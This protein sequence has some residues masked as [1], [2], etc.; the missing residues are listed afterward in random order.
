MYLAALNMARKLN[1]LGYKAKITSDLS[2]TASLVSNSRGMQADIF[3]N[4]FAAVAAGLG[5]LSKCGFVINP[6]HGAE[7]RYLA[8]V[9]DAKLDETA[10]CDAD[11]A[12]A[13]ASCD[14]CL[15]ACRT[16]A[17]QEMIEFELDGLTEKFHRID[18]NRCEWAKRYSFIPE[19][20]NMFMG[21]DFKIETPDQVT[22]DNLTEAMRQTPP[23][24]KHHACNFEK[25]FMACPVV[26]DQKQ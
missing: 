11:P 14:S 19:S 20:G 21:W 1:K 25:C 15:N 3:S 8:I 12:S 4:S 7:M 10:L 26:R 2:N 17:F 23:I 6:E 5:R 16:K 24:S 9:T 18:T 22:K 13:C